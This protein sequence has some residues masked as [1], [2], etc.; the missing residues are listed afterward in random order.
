MNFKIRKR[1]LVLQHFDYV[2]MW[3]SVQDWERLHGAFKDMQVYWNMLEWK[4]TQ[5]EREQVTRGAAHN[6]LPHSMKYIQLDLRDL[7]SQVSNQVSTVFLLRSMHVSG[8]LLEEV[9][10]M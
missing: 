6:I 4:R 2:I 8:P 9:T 10:P 5:L 3:L 7:M 1:G